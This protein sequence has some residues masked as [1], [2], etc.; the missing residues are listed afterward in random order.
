[1]TANGFP[2]FQF[3]ID[4]WQAGKIAAFDLEEQGFY[5]NLCIL[6]WV[7]MGSFSVCSTTVQRRYRKPAEWVASTVAAFVDVGIIYADGDKYRIKFIDD[8]IELLTGKRQQRVDAGKA[9]AAKRAAALLSSESTVESK[10]EK[11]REEK[12]SA[13][14]ERS[15]SV[16]RSLDAGFSLFWIA[17]P[18]KVGKAAAL[19]AWQK[20][21]GKPD[22]DSILDAVRNQSQSEQWNKDGGQFIPNP[23][24][25]LN[26]GRWDD[27]IQS[28]PKQVRNCI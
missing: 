16:Q 2:Y 23:A 28:K 10:V 11:R 7:G 3:H 26:Q 25:W 9:S 13:L 17:Y 12:S 21:K 15:T 27:G 4:K 22:V 18:R 14:N 20:A 8:Q 5:L 19:K 24:T 6:A 1:M